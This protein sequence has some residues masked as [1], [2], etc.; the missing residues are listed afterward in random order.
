MTF[1]QVKSR[2]SIFHL[3]FYFP[4]LFG[5]LFP[6][7]IWTLISLFFLDFYF[8]FLFGLLLSFLFFFNSVLFFFNSIAVT[9]L[10]FFQVFFGILFPFSIWT[11]LFPFSIWT[12]YFQFIFIFFNF[13]SILFLFACGHILDFFHFFL[14]LPSCRIQ[15]TI[16][17]GL[18]LYGSFR[19]KVLEF[20]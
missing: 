11:F 4:F 15:I 3:D 20:L 8:P 18:A 10:G 13:F 7:S 14:C 6:F 1:F 9:H 16:S 2:F 17:S 19:S 5:L 12:F